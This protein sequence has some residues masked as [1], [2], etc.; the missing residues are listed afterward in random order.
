MSNGPAQPAAGASAPPPPAGATVPEMA[1]AAPAVVA[2]VGQRL[3]LRDEFFQHTVDPRHLLEPFNHIPGLLYFVKDAESRLMAISHESV[4]R[5]GFASDSEIIGRTVREYL[6]GDLSGKFLKDDQ[7]VVREGKPLRN[8]VEMWYN[9][10]GQRDWIVTDKYPLRD[11]QGRVVGLVGTIQSFEA[12]RQMLAHLGP[13]GKA[14]DYIRDHLGEPMM[15]GDIAKA[16]GFSER[17]LQRLFRRV[18]GMTIQQFIIQS[19]VHAAVHEL[20]HSDQPIAEIAAQLGFN[21]QS[22]FTNKFRAVTGLPPRRYRERY[23]A[24]LTQ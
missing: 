17:Q 23:L 20:T 2:P 18:F 24:G 5:M 22:A 6:P 3:R 16:A 19:R 11:G 15:I 4:V 14:A 8:L 9:A 13:V 7:R 21:D 12:R 1:A 10:E